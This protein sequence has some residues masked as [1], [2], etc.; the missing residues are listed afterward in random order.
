MEYK[1]KISVIVPVYNVEKY[2]EETLDSVINQSIGFKKNIQLI[3]VNDGSP[4]NSGDICVKYRDMYPDNIIYVEKENG[5]V[6][7]ARNAGI[8]Y[9]QGKYVNFLDSD[10]KW[11]LHAF[12]RAYRFFEKHYNEIDVLSCRIKFFDAKDSFH[13]LDYKFDEGTRI[14]DLNSEEELFT[15]QSTVAPTFIKSKEIVNKRFDTKLKFGEDSKFINSII[16][17]KCKFGVIKNALFLYRRRSD[18]SSAVNTQTFKKSYYLDTIQNFHQKMIEMSLDKYGKVIPYFQSVIAYD[19][20]WR[21]TVPHIHE[22]L[23][24]DEFNEFCKI[25]GEVLSFIDER[26]ILEN[27]VH[28]SVFRKAEAMKLK[29]GKPFFE[30]LELEEGALKYGQSELIVLQ[31]NKTNCCLVTNFIITDKRCKLEMLVSEWLFSSTKSK[32]VLSL[33]VGKNFYTPEEQPY[34]HTKANTIDGKINYYRLCTFEFDL[35][36]KKGK[37][38]KIK[39]FLTYGDNSTSV[40]MGY[41][42][43]IPTTNAFAQAYQMQGRYA[44]RFFR[45]VISVSAPVK[46]RKERIKL[47]IGCISLL[48]RKL[49]FKEAF[50]RIKLPFFKRSN[51]PKGDIWLISDRIDNAGDNGEVLF[52]YICEHKPEGVRPIFVIGE[53]A[54]EEVKQRLEKTGEVL[55]FESKK[56]PYYFLSA[57]RIIS[58]SGGEFT[59][60]PFGKEKKYFHSLFNF[61]YSYLQH[62]VTC[63][64]LSAWLNRFNKN[65]E[66]FFVSGKRE[67]EA[68]L[69]SDYYYEPEQL[70]LSGQARFD[71]LYNDPQKQILIMPTWRRNIKQSY[72]EKTSSVYFDG[73]RDTD[74]FKFYNS[75]INDERL[76]S[77][78]RNKG[79]KGLFC[80]HPIHMKQYVDY[81]ENDVFSVNEGYVDYNKV[82][83]ESS[84]MVTDYSSVLFDYAYL[85]KPVVYAQ[86]DKEEFF[87]GQIYDEGYFKYERDGFG[88]VCY[89]LDE[90]VNELIRLIENDCKNSKEYLDRVNSFF[91]FN[92]K[93]NSK[94]IL[95]AI[96]E[97]D[98]Q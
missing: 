14:V 22:V 51:K 65:I 77:V 27:P 29:T 37:T 53:G 19:L 7:S 10:D 71:A 48:L 15:I 6:S 59:I 78:M 96:L 33:K 30:N 49:K 55:Y 25:S 24:E 92:D 45:T 80:L 70:I 17:N 8:E 91:E 13:T 73:F 20:L 52:R 87:E 97:K 1:Y 28:T 42:K 63:A 84:V 12:K 35:K 64:D 31:R 2:L 90:T 85:R 46:V 4:D 69:S 44:I 79:Y 26:I 9:I 18:D 54:K 34:R 67:R 93:N 72:D 50:I 98:K 36:V 16:I 61:K 23:N 66:L 88:K 81:Q 11:D 94:R 68:I 62:G 74:Y 82:F 95:E 83:A 3:L 21:F 41:G 43:F 60:N 89:D 47:E 57:K 76:L 38:I 40:S 56:Y 75:L 58:S 86:F 32:G 39:P 5:G